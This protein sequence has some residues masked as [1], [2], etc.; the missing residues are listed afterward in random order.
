MNYIDPV[1]YSKLLDKFAKGTTKSILKENYIDLVPVNYLN[2]DMEEET[3]IENPGKYKPKS[4]DLDGDGVP[5]GA[6]KAPKD[7]SKQEGLHR[8]RDLSRL[9][10]DEQKQLK[11]YI[12]S[13]K[14]IKRAIQ[15][16][17]AKATVME[18]DTTGKI[19]TPEVEEGE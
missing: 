1:N 17:V 7:G 16:L 14:E 2:E 12:N 4:Y 15:E 10:I 9:S 8:D 11:E 3:S 18:S 6:D 13:V 19:L 5:N